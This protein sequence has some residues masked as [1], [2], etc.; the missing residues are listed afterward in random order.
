MMRELPASLNALM[1]LCIQVDDCLRARQS[2]QRQPFREPPASRDL[3]PDAQEARAFGT[4][5]E[6][7]MQLGRSRLTLAERQRRFSAGECL[8]CGRRGHF[9]SACPALEKG[10]AR[11]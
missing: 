1:S 10:G 2:S 5:E 4:E 3:L 9:I 7:P 11:Q 6:V 8:Y